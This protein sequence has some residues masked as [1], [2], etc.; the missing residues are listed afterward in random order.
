MQHFRC[1]YQTFIIVFMTFA[2]LLFG[3]YAHSFILLSLSRCCCP[4]GRYKCCVIAAADCKFQ[5]YDWFAREIRQYCYLGCW[6]RHVLF[7]LVGWPQAVGKETEQMLAKVMVLLCA[8]TG[9][10]WYLWRLFWACNLLFATF[11]Y[12]FPILLQ[13]V[14]TRFNH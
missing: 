1:D 10:F 9:T 7:R 11:D 6:S 12:P 4:V 8:V 14:G 2:D 5:T 3:T 13:Y